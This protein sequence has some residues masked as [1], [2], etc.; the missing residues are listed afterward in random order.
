MPYS[1][2]VEELV[3][4]PDRWV[5]PVAARMSPSHAA[6]ADCPSGSTSWD[7]QVDLAHF[8][9]SEVLSDWADWPLGQTTSFRFEFICLPISA[10]GDLSNRTFRF[11]VNPEPGYVDG[12]IYL[13]DEHHPA[14]LTELAFG[15]LSGGTIEA[16]FGVDVD[17]GGPGGAGFRN[18]RF[19][20][21]VPVGLPDSLLP[22]RS[23]A[24]SRRG[25]IA[26]R[27]AR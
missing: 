12:S 16:W 25:D 6:V 8:D 10:A 15:R 5:R 9:V 23:P 20:F 27:S 1:R 18:R 24:G 3:D 7:I 4:F 2:S 17:F 11:P 19:Q 21:T 22:S 13:I 14:D 26:S